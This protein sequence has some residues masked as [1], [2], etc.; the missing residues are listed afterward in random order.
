VQQPE[1]RRFFLLDP[2]RISS[3]KTCRYGFLGQDIENIVPHFAFIIDVLESL[4]ETLQWGFLGPYI[5]NIALHF[6]FISS[7]TF[8]GWILKALFFFS[9]SP[10]LL[11]DRSW[12]AF[13]GIYW[14]RY[15]KHLSAFWLRHRYC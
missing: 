12:K 14:T 9:P 2:L 1:V 11:L 3:A 7:G 13:N 6:A 4:R 10:S 8:L 5:R 15:L